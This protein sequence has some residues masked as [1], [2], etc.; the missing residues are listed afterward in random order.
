MRTED[1]VGLSFFLVLFVG[2]GLILFG[3]G[4]PENSTARARRLSAGLAV[5]GFA[6]L[7][8]GA[9]TVYF[10][11]TSARLQVEGNLWAVNDSI[12]LS[13]FKVTDDSGRVASIRCRYQGP[14]LRD[15]DRARV[16]YRE[17]DERLVEL[18]ILNGSYA[19]WHLQDSTNEW[20]G[21]WFALIGLGCGAG[22]YR[23][24]E[25]SRV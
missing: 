23:L 22:A 12:H 9:I 25:R 8:F 7:T 6:L 18:T 15:G 5:T 2:V 10:T 17:Y 21:A 1:I 16:R 19:G 20:S 13:S 24:R 11:H 4:R 3:L 14:G